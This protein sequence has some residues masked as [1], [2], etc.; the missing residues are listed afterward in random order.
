VVTIK[1]KWEKFDEFAR[2]STLKYMNKLRLDSYLQK[3]DS[4]IVAIY[5]NIVFKASGQRIEVS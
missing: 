1:F 4:P 2:F 5:V 3:W